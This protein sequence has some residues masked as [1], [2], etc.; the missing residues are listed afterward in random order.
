MRETEKYKE[1]ERQRDRRFAHSTIHYS[2]TCTHDHAF[3]KTPSGCPN[4]SSGW[5]E[6]PG[7]RIVDI[8]TKALEAKKATVA[9]GAGGT[10]GAS[11]SART[12]LACGTAN[13]LNQ[14]SRCKEVFFC[15]RACQRSSWKEH[16]KTC[17][18]A[19]AAA[20]PPTEEKAE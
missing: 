6:L 7:P 12:C 4:S 9:G 16:K 1:R 18:V 17:V 20:A 13:P 11:G 15:D 14:C 2:Q 3:R 8:L 19:V 10:G 5:D